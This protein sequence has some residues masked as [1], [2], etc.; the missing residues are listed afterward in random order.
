MMTE[1]D[2]NTSNDIDVTAGGRIVGRVVGE[3][4][5]KRCRA[6]IHQ[7]KT[8]PGWALD[9]QSLTDAESYGARVVEIHDTETSITYAATIERIRNKGFAFNRG[10]GQQ[11]CLPLQHWVVEHPGARQL[12]LSMEAA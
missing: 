6:S 12:A 10:F 3:R 1:R 11:I 4:F 2:Y 5:V 8:P 7:L 9:S